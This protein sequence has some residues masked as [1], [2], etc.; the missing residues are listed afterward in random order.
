MK[1]ISLEIDNAVYEQT[2]ELLLNENT[3]RDRYIN[4][5]LIYYNIRMHKRKMLGDILKKASRDCEKSSKEVLKEF[6]MIEDY[7]F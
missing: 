7:V 4:E 2:E 3:P 5:A 1:T 6:E